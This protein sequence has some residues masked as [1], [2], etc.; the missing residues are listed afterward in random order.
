MLSLPEPLH[1]IAWY[2]AVR[3]FDAALDHFLDARPGTH[4]RAEAYLALRRAIVT[5]DIAEAAYAR[6]KIAGD[7]LLDA[8]PS[9][10]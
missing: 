9:R 3:D 5:W 10:D 2:F 8:A 7:A 6:H 1:E 4:D